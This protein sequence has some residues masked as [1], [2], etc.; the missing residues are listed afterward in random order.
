MKKRFALVLVAAGLVAAGCSSDDD[1]DSPDVDGPAATDTPM[2]TTD[3]DVTDPDTD[4]EVGDAGGVAGGEGD[5]VT[6]GPD[7]NAGPVELAVAG[8]P[9][10][11]NFYTLLDSLFGGETLDE[12][13]PPQAWT[14]FLPTNDAFQAGGADETPE[15]GKLLLLRR[16][17]ISDGKLSGEDLAALS[18]IIVN[19]GDSYPI[20]GDASS[21]AVGG[22]NVLEV[23]AEDDD[24]IVYGID[25][26]LQ[27]N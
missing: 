8:A 10:Y 3:G 20:T 25:G 23:L 13:D 19:T 27:P 11:S 17:V 14:F 12:R 22:A 24:T 21:L 2:T 9:E 18:E 15:D 16:H 5:A 6:D 7:E 1:G 4:V 26:V